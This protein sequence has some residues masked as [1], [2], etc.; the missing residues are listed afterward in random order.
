[1]KPTRREFLRN[2]WKVGGA[3]LAVAGGWTIYESLR[4]LSTRARGAKIA[5]GHLTDFTSDSATYVSDGRLYV[6]NAGGKELFAL[7]Q[8][9]PHL[10]CR[11]PYCQ[12]SG[13]FE[14]PCHGS[15]YDIA[16]EYISGPAPRGMDRFPLSLEGDVVFVDTS[17][18]ILGPARGTNAYLTP[19]RGPSCIHGAG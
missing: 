12:T 10:G 17:E 13:R 11:V 16:G 9:C 18:T 5:V 8:K 7:S 14:C 6:A 19:P 1:M 15:I 4:P 2:A 3:A